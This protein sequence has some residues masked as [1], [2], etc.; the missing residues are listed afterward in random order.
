[1][2]AHT[3]AEGQILPASWQEA[4]AMNVHL[5]DGTYE[6]FRTYF[7]APQYKN[8][9]GIEVGATR[10]LLRTLLSLLREPQV[11]H[12]ACAFDHVIESFRNELFPGY[13][14]GEGLDPALLGQFELAERATHA[15]GIVTWPMIEFE[16]DDALAT[17]ADRFANDPRVTQVVICSPDKDLAQC[18]RGERI[19]CLDRL[20]KRVL[21]ERGVVEKFGVPPRVIPDYLALVGD[22]ADGLPGVPRWG[23]RSAAALLARFGSIDAIPE[24]PASWGVPVRGALALAESLLVHRERAALYRQLATLRN[25]VPLGETLDDLEWRGVRREPFL[26]LCEE[27]GET[28]LQERISLWRD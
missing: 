17:A 27:L 16:A 21:D 8:A 2:H 20:R 13:K 3:P 24:N 25:D 22:S 14:T 26:S 28:E 11:T 4:I 9:A 12:S 23:A 5:I 19:V 18:V 1:V 15:L 7:G 6:L 10:G